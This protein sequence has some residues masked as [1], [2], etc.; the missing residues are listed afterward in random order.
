MQ[1]YEAY[2]DSGIEWIG[3]I[4]AG[5]E[6]RRLKQLCHMES[7]ATPSKENLE[8]WDGDIPWVSSKEVKDPL[9]FDTSLH[10]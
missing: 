8:Y 1:R 4:P 9:I 3:E 5:W 2:K 7:G 10:I 6:I